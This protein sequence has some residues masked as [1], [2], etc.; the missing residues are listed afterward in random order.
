MWAPRQLPPSSMSLKQLKVDQLI[1]NDSSAHTPLSRSKLRSNRLVDWDLEAALE[2]SLKDDNKPDWILEAAI[3]ASLEDVN[4]SDGI[5]NENH[6]YGT[7]SVP[8]ND[9]HRR[10]ND[11]SETIIDTS[12]YNDGGKVNGCID[13]FGPYFGYGFNG[14]SGGYHWESMEDAEI[15]SKDNASLYKRD[16]ADDTEIDYEVN[17]HD[18][19]HDEQD[20]VIEGNEDEFASDDAVHAEILHEVLQCVDGRTAEDNV[21]SVIVSLDAEEDDTMAAD[22]EQIDT[23]DETL[24]GAVAE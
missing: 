12:I 16:E 19:R 18:A 17:L 3:K 23:N 5:G 24:L 4:H 7:I 10:L 15:A 1:A 6:F 22:V 8:Y 2:A 21:E 14:V 11:N 13:N 20:E 9:I